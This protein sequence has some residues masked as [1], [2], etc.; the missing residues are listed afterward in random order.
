MN[1]K[2]IIYDDSCPMCS[3]YTNAFV[4][5]GFIDKEGRKDFSTIS[6]ALLAKID[7]QKSVNEIPLIDTKTNTI[8]YGIDA[9]LE[10]LDEKIPFIKK[11]GNIKPIKWLLQKLYKFIS[12]NGRVIVAIPKKENGFDC[13]PGFNT[14]YRFAFLATF[15]LFNTWMLFPLQAHVLNKSIFN[16][17][18]IKLQVVHTLF[19]CINI[20]IGT[21]LKKKDGYEYL[22]QIN[23]VA[24]LAMLCSVPLICINKI[25]FLPNGM[26]NS[27]YLG[28]LAFFVV[29]EYLRRMRYIGFNRRYKKILLVNISSLILFITYMML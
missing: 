22:G 11:T 5:T 21:S 2:I 18:I 27:F 1:N 25:F 19:V 26:F 6:P 29:H 12:Y 17:N 3:A 20:G 14:R 10:V 4:K 8:W 24:L 13:S 28:M 23:M 7:I 9:L 16:S 15:L